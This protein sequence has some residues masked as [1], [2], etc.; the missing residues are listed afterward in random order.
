MEATD[1][2]HGTQAGYRAHRRAS[3]SACIPCRKAASAAAAKRREYEAALTGG[4][5]VLGPRRVLVWEPL[6]AWA[7]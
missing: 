6:K 5:W 1:P 2:R 4:R 7:S 3:Q